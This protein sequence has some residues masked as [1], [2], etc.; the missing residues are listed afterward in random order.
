MHDDVDDELGKDGSLTVMVITQFDSRCI[1]Q[2][3]LASG[4]QSSLTQSFST[5]LISSH[6]SIMRLV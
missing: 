2:T 5:N 4:T 6:Q 3:A 1:Q